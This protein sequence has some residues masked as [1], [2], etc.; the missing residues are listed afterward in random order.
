MYIY[1]YICDGLFGVEHNCEI[2]WNSYVDVC[3]GGRIKADVFKE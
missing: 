2:E 1:R 3:G